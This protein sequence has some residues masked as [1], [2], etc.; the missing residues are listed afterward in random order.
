ML[1]YCK[2]SNL[3]WTRYKQQWQAWATILKLN[4]EE[5]FSYEYQ[6]LNSILQRAMSKDFFLP[7]NFLE[8]Y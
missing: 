7:H 4:K 2:I 3:L 5:I 6:T 1:N 8:S